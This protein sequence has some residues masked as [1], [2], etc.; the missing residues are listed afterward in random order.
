MSLA[1][2]R[3]ARREPGEAESTQGFAPIPGEPEARR[4]VT[5]DGPTSQRNER[6]RVKLAGRQGFEPR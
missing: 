5:E 1:I 3:R 6:E 2:R 4:D